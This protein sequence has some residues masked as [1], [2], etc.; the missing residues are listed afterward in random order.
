M[1]WT[2]FFFLPYHKTSSARYKDPATVFIQLRQSLSELRG[3]ET[4]YKE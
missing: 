1:L 4:K 3:H 2:A